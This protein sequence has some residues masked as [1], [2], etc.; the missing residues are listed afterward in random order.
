VHLPWLGIDKFTTLG[1][2]PFEVHEIDG[3]RVGMN[4]CYDSGFPEPGRCL[5]L[6]G[7]DLIALPTNWPPGAECMAEHAVPTRAMENGVYFAAVNRV[8]TERGFQFIGR[9]SI[10]A[11][12][13]DV[14]ARA[15]A[16]NEEILYADIDPARARNK[17]IVRVPSKHVIDRMADRRPEMY[18]PLVEPH[19]LS[20]PRDDAGAAR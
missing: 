7:A 5:T 12:N 13:G 14:L 10:C 15:S 11:P 8:G 16:S 19:A 18:G 2:R 3:L 9:S 6:L 4:I 1:D 17:R 20:R